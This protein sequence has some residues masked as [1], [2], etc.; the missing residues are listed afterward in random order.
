MTDGRI[1][2][3]RYELDQ[4]LGRGGMGEVWAALDRDTKRRVA[5]KL[6]TARGGRGAEVEARFAREILAT[7]QLASKHVVG[8]HDAGVDDDTGQSFMVVDLLDG[9]DLEQLAERVGTFRVAVALALAAQACSGLVVAHAAGVVHRDIKPSNLFVTTG[10]VVKILDFGVARTASADAERI[11]STG[12][13]IGSP[14]YMSPEQLRGERELDHRADLWSL[15]VV[16]Y[17]LLCGH[18]PHDSDSI[19]DL[20]VAIGSEPAPPLR[21]R[22][23]WLPAEVAAVVHRALE[24]EPARRFASARE[25]AAALAALLPD[26]DSS[27]DGRDFALPAQAAQAARSAQLAQS[28][29]FAESAE[30]V[31]SAQLAQPARLPVAPPPLRVVTD[32]PRAPSAMPRRAAVLGIVGGAAAAI[33]AVVAVRVVTRTPEPPEPPEAPETPTVIDKPHVLNQTGIRDLSPELDR[34]PAGHWWYLYHR[35]CTPGA[36]A[37]VFRDDPPP[38]SPEGIAFTVACYAVAGD[39]VKARAVRDAA[40]PAGRAYSVLP[41]FDLQHANADFDSADPATAPIMQ[42]VVEAWPGNYQALYDLGIA[43]LPSEPAKAAR[44]LRAFVAIKQDRTPYLTTAR[45]VLAQ[46]AHPDC[47]HPIIDPTGRTLRI[48]TCE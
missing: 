31:Q 37:K 13:L 48:P 32:E 26:G 40:P 3:R 7:A 15:G 46:L 10:N 23:P 47:G 30:L 35:L 6:L 5:V 41:L 21:A 43:E 11:T 39:Y 34:S 20:I 2:A 45:A 42:I 22:A 25:M 44:D 9:E 14:L 33:A 4:L 28:A 38:P 27:I 36:V 18:V 19:G 1:I 24:I 8:V 29:P 17:R 16:L 12:A